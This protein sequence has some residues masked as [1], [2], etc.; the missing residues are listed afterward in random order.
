M[1]GSID[2]VAWANRGACLKSFRDAQVRM[3]TTMD[4]WKGSAAVL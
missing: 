3:R 4:P 2:D 1:E